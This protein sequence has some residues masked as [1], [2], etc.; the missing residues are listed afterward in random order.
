M[1]AFSHSTTRFICWLLAVLM[2]V[3]PA[4][5][6]VL[7]ENPI[8]LDGR[9]QTTISEAGGNVTNI[10]TETKS[11]VT[12]FNS[13]E[14]FNVLEDHTV[15]LHLPTGTVNLIN[16]VSGTEQTTISG[17]LNSVLADGS[18]GGNLYLLN[19]NGILVG[20]S[21]T[22]N[23]G[24]L[25]MATASRSFI[26]NL[27]TDPISYT[28]DA[29]NQKVLYSPNEYL[30]SQVLEGSIPLTSN[31]S[32]IVKGKINAGFKVELLANH[33]SI[34]EG[35]AVQLD[36][37]FR[38]PYSE[39][40]N[41]QGIEQAADVEV[42]DS[43]TIRILGTRDV[44]I[45]G[46]VSADGSEKHRD[47]GSI[48]IETAGGDYSNTT[49]DYTKK[50]IYLDEN[51]KE[52]YENTGNPLMGEVQY[53]VKKKDASGNDTPFAMLFA[54]ETDAQAE[55]YALLQLEQN[56]DGSLKVYQ[57]GD[58]KYCKKL[59]GTHVS[60]TDDS[61][62]SL[63]FFTVQEQE[64][65]VEAN[66]VAAA[67]G[68]VNV[69]LSPSA[70]IHANGAA[71]SGTLAR[72]NGGLIEVAADHKIQIDASTA[73]GIFSANG[74]A[75]GSVELTSNLVDLSG[76]V[77]SSGDFS[78]KASAIHWDGGSDGL[79]YFLKGGS[80]FNSKV[81]G[82]K[83][84]SDGI[85][86][87]STGVIHLKN[88]HI[89]TRS[90]QEQVSYASGA[91]RWQ[92]HQTADSTGNSGSVTIRADALE[93][94][95]SDILTSVIASSGSGT[96]LT[97]GK[98]TIRL[99]DHY[100]S[101]LTVDG[102]SYEVG[103]SMK[104]STLDAG[105]Y[106]RSPSG[107]LSL[108]D[109]A[110]V[111]IEL[112]DNSFANILDFG[113]RASAGFAQDSTSR[114]TG[115]S[116][117]LKV[118][119]ASGVALDSSSADPQKVKNY[120]MTLLKLL[121]DLTSLVASGRN[122]QSRA[123]AN[124]SGTIQAS[125]DL[126]VQT[127]SAADANF[128]TYGTNLGC[129]VVN[130]LAWSDLKIGSTAS[131]AANNLSVTSNLSTSI[132]AG[133]ANSFLG[134]S[135]SIGCIPVDVGATIVLLE[136][137]NNL[138]VEAGATLKAQK[139]LTLKALTTNEI[140]ANT[141]SCGE[142][143]YLG[144]AFTYLGTNV[145]T[146]LTL[147]DGTEASHVTL[148]G[149]TLNVSAETKL[150]TSNSAY[151]KVGG[152]AVF[153][154]ETYLNGISNGKLA[155]IQGGISDWVK[156][157][158]SFLKKVDTSKFGM[159]FATAVQ[160]SDAKNRLIVG[161][162]SVLTGTSALNLTS[163]MTFDYQNYAYSMMG[164]DYSQQHAG[165]KGLTNVTAAVGLPVLIHS[166]TTALDVCQNAQLRGD[167]ISLAATTTI[168]YSF[169]HLFN[170]LIH[171]DFSKLSAQTL[172]DVL[173]DDTL[174]LLK[175]T[176]NSM[177][178]SSTEAKN[179]GIAGAI[180]VQVITNSSTLKVCDGVKI[181]GADGLSN[182]SSF[183]ASAK[184]D[185]TSINMAG[186]L[187]SFFA[188][189]PNYK[190]DAAGKKKWASCFQSMWG[191]NAE[192]A[193]GA[194]VLWTQFDDT[195]IADVSASQILAK[196]VDV[197]AKS[198]IVNV[199]ISVGAG[200]AKSFGFEGMFSVSNLS[201][202][203]LAKIDDSTAI[204]SAAAPADSVSVTANDAIVNVTVAGSILKSSGSEKTQVT[205]GVGAGIS[206]LNRETYAIWGNL[207]DSSGNLGT[208]K[209]YSQAETLAAAVTPSR[210]RNQTNVSAK[211][212]GVDVVYALSGTLNST[213]D[214]GPDP[215]GNEQGIALMN[216]FDE[217]GDNHILNENLHSAV[218]ITADAS[219]SLI[220]E[221][222]R[223]LLN[224][225]SSL[226]FNPDGT[227]KIGSGASKISV[228][229][230][231]DSFHHA[232]A[233]SASF[234]WGKAYGTSGGLAG[235][236]AFI[237]DTATTQAIL[238]L[239]EMNYYSGLTSGFTTSPNQIL[240]NV[241]AKKS[242]EIIALAISADGVFTRSDTK[243]ALAGSGSYV[244]IRDDTDALVTGTTL[245]IGSAGSTLSDAERLKLQKLADAALSAKNTADIINIAG[246]VSLG[247]SVGVGGAVGIGVIEQNTNALLK[248]VAI[249]GNSLAV[250]TTNSGLIVNVAVGTA[251]SGK[252]E[253]GFTFSGSVAIGSVSGTSQA[254]MVCLTGTGL[255]N[256][257][258][259]V[260]NLTG[261]LSV[262]AANS[263]KLTEEKGAS[264]NQF[265]Y[266]QLLTSEEQGL[267]NEWN[268]K[269]LYLGEDLSTV[270]IKEGE[271][272][273]ING[274]RGE[275]IN[276]NVQ[277]SFG[278]DKARI[279]SVGAAV[280]ASKIATG[281]VVGVNQVH[282]TH[283]AIL[284]DAQ[285]TLGGSAA[286]TS[287]SNAGIYAFNVGFSVSSTANLGLSVGVNLLTQNTFVTVKDSTLT[288][289]FPA[290]GTS[291]VRLTD[292]FLAN[293]S[294]LIV[295]ASV[296][297]GIGTKES[298]TG[299]LLASW[300]QSGNQTMVQ[301]ENSTITNHYGSIRAEGTSSSSLI[302]ILI[303]AGISSKSL[304]GN[305]NVAINSIGSIGV[306]DSTDREN[307]ISDALT[308]SY[309]ITSGNS[310]RHQS[311]LRVTQGSAL[312]AAY[313]NLDLTAKT[314]GLLVAVGLSISGGKVGAATLSG[315]YAN[316]GAITV[317]E[318]ANS[319]LTA[320]EYVTTTVDAAVAAAVQNSK[321]TL[322]EAEKKALRD[323]FTT[324][325]GE[326]APDGSGRV[327]VASE[328]GGNI[329]LS[330]SDSSKLI[331]IVVGGAGG[332]KGAVAVNCGVSTV[333]QSLETLL[334]ASVITASNQIASNLSGDGLFIM[335]G[336]NAAIGLSG[337]GVGINFNYMEYGTTMKQIVSD[338]SITSGFGSID[339]SNRSNED[340]YLVSA[341]GAISQYVSVDANVGIAMLSNTNLVR[342]TS[343]ADLTAGGNVLLAA[344]STNHIFNLT[345]TVAIGGAGGGIGANAVTSKVTTNT[346]V[347]VN[348]DGGSANAPTSI[349]SA[350][351]FQQT[352]KLMFD[353]NEV[354]GTGIYA[355]TK[356][357]LQ[358]L[359]ISAA[360]GEYFGVSGNVSVLINKPTTKT[361]VT[362]TDLNLR[363]R[364]S[365]YLPLLIYYDA[366]GELQFQEASAN[367]KA[368]YTQNA[369]LDASGWNF[370]GGLAGGAGGVQVGI[371][372]TLLEPTTESILSSIR[373]VREMMPG[374][375]SFQGITPVQ[376][377]G[378]TVSANLNDVSVTAASTMD[379]MA[380]QGGAAGG[381]VG[382]SGGYSLLKLS[383]ATRAQILSSDLNAHSLT[384]DANS[385]LNLQSYSV[386][387]GGGIGGVV[388]AGAEVISNHD[389]EAAVGRV[390]NDSALHSL[391]LSG[392][393]KIN[394]AASLKLRN[395]L[396][397]V[398]G[399]A[400]A[401]IVN[402]TRIHGSDSALA[403]IADNYVVT[404][405]RNITMDARHTLTVEEI[406]GQLAGGGAVGI[407][408]DVISMQSGAYVQV[409]SGT[410]LSARG[411]ASL[412][413]NVFNN[414]QL[415]DIGINVGL[416]GIQASISVIN[417]S[418]SA[419][420]ETIRIS[421]RDY[422]AKY[423]DSVEKSNYDFATL[424]RG[425][426][427]GGN[428]VDFLQGKMDVGDEFRDFYSTASES[429]VN[430][431]LSTLMASAAQGSGSPN[432]GAVT[433]LS[434][435]QSAVQLGKE[436]RISAGGAVTIQAQNH[437]DFDFTTVAT[438][439]EGISLGGAINLSYLG[440]NV[441]TQIG[442]DVLSD[443]SIL[444]G[445]SDAL[446][447]KDG[448]ASASCS[449]GIGQ[450]AAV[451][452]AAGVAY[453]D[454][455]GT[456]RIVL[457]GASRESTAS[458]KIAQK[459][460]TNNLTKSA[461][462]SLNA[463]SSH[464]YSIQNGSVDV[465]GAGAAGIVSHILDTS[466]ASI[467][468]TSAVNLST[469]RGSINLNAS[470]NTNYELNTWG[471][472]VNLVGAVGDESFLR[473]GTAAKVTLADGS[474]VRAGLVAQNSGPH[475]FDLENE[476]DPNSGLNSSQNNSEN[477][478]DSNDSEEQKN[479]VN[480][481]TMARSTGK[482]T[483]K[484]IDA[485]V[486][487]T[488]GVSRDIA[489]SSMDSIITL[490]NDVTLAGDSVSL[491]AQTL[492]QLTGKGTAAGGSL[493][494]TANSAEAYFTGTHNA[495][496]VTGSRL[497]AFTWA[498][499]EGQR[500]GT[501]SM[502][503][504]TDINSSLEAT[505][506]GGSVGIAIGVV[507]SKN[508][509]T[510]N[511]VIHVGSD[512]ILRAGTVNLTAE[513]ASKIASDLTGGAGAILA[514]SGNVLHSYYTPTAEITFD[515]NSAG[516]LT[517]KKRNI[518]ADSVLLK[519]LAAGSVDHRNDSR[520]G[521]LVSAGGAG[522]RFGIT[523]V[524]VLN[525]ANIQIEAP[526]IRIQ[527]LTDLLMP[528][529]DENT[530]L[531]SGGLIDAAATRGNSV[532]LS[533]ESTVNIGDSAL[534]TTGTA[535]TDGLL[536]ISAENNLTSYDKYQLIAGAAIAVTHAD[537]ELNID[538]LN[539][540]VN[541]GKNA[542]LFSNQTF[543][544]GALSNA[545]VFFSVVSKSYGLAGV[546]VSQG[547]MLLNSTNTVN[548]GEGAS[549]LSW[550]TLGLAA[551]GL[552]D[553]VSKWNL[554]SY[555]YAYTG[556]AIPISASSTNHHYFNLANNIRT[557]ANSK[558]QSVGDVHLLS[559]AG[560]VRNVA[561][562]SSANLYST[563]GSSSISEIFTDGSGKLNSSSKDSNIQ[564]T[565]GVTIAGEVAAGIHAD[566]FFLVKP[567]D[568]S[569]GSGDAPVVTCSDWFS[570][571]L[572]EDVALDLSYGEQIANLEAEIAKFDQS[573]EKAYADALRNELAYLKLLQQQYAGQKADIISL[574]SNSV[575]GGDVIAHG[576]Y[577]ATEGSQAILRAK[578]N[579]KLEVTND[580]GAFLQTANLTVSGTGNGKLVFNANQIASQDQ[581]NRL[582]RENKKAAFSVFE[583][584]TQSSAV[585][586][587]QITSSVSKA[588]LW[589]NGTILNDYGSVVVNSKGSIRQAG[590][591]SAQ[592]VKITTAGSFIQDYTAGMRNLGGNPST[593][594]AVLA[595]MNAFIYRMQNSDTENPNYSGSTAQN[596]KMTSNSSLV[597]GGSVFIA[598]EYLNLNGMI[599]SGMADYA[600]D[601]GSNGILDKVDAFLSEFKAGRTSTNI[602]DLTSDIQIS[603]SG[604]TS[605]IPVKVQF[606]AET[607]TL[608]VDDLI[609]R[610]GSIT[611]YGNILSTGNGVIYAASGRSSVSISNPSAYTLSLGDI[612]VSTAAAGRVSITDTAYQLLDKNGK[613]TGLNT[614]FESQSGQTIRTSVLYD[615]ATRKILY[616][617]HGNECLSVTAASTYSPLANRWYAW[618]TQ[619][620][621][622]KMQ[623]E[624]KWEKYVFWI[625]AGSS[626]S[627]GKTAVTVNP[628][629]KVLSDTLVTDA[630]LDSS[631]DFIAKY[632]RKESDSN[633][634]D[635]KYVKD[636]TRVFV[637]YWEE[638]YERTHT[639]KETESFYYYLNASKPVSVGFN[640]AQ[641]GGN[642]TISSQGALN[643]ASIL[644]PGGSVSITTE[645]P[646][647]RSG[648]SSVIQSADISLTV[649][650]GAKSDLLAPESI[651][652]ENFALMVRQT[653]DLGKPLS[654]NPILN[655][656]AAFGNV[657]LQNT[658][659]STTL[660][661]VNVRG[662][663]L[664]LKSSGSILQTAGS[665]I[666]AR[667]LNLRSESGNV[668]TAGTPLRVETTTPDRTNG[669]EG[670]VSVY[671]MGDVHLREMGRADGANFTDSD[672]YVEKIQS[673]DGNAAITVA[674]GSI[675]N[676]IQTPMLFGDSQESYHA[677]LEEN[678]MVA[679]KA[680][681]EQMNQTFE[682]TEIVWEMLYHEN[683]NG[684]K[685]A[686][687]PNYAFHFTDEQRAQM[688]ASGLSEETIAGQEAQKT[689]FYHET[690]FDYGNASY[691]SKFNYSLAAEERQA[692]SVGSLMT[693]QEMDDLLPLETYG[694]D[695]PVETDLTPHILGR[696]I[697][698]TTDRGIGSLDE[699]LIIPAGTSLKDLSP[700]D[701]DS[702][703]LALPQDVSYLRG[704]DGKVSAMVVQRR[705][706]IVVEATGVVDAKA[707][708]D[709][710]LAS[711]R[712]LTLNSLT[713]AN[714]N[715]LLTLKGNLKANSQLKANNMDFT[716][717]GNVGTETTPVDVLLQGTDTV[718][719]AWAKGS[720][721]FRS[722]SD[723]RITSIRTE[724]ASGIQ[725]ETT[726][727][728]SVLGVDSESATAHLTANQIR[729]TSDG[730]IGT[731]AHA[732]IT[733]A[734]V[735][736]NLP[737]FANW[738]E[739]VALNAASD[740]HLT[741][742]DSLNVVRAQ[743]AS[744]DLTLTAKLQMDLTGNLA[745]KNV[746]L[747]TL[748]N[749]L[750]QAAEGSTV[751]STG[752]ES[753]VR[754]TA[755]QNAV[756]ASVSAEGQTVNVT[757]EEGSILRS[758]A[759]TT[760]NAANAA[761]ALT[762]AT[763]VGSAQTADANTF[764]DALS[765]NV[766]SVTGSVSGA[767]GFF[768]EQLTATPLTASGI[769]TASGS[770]GLLATGA[771]LVKDVT[772][773]G[774]GTAQGDLFVA[775]Q[776]AD[777]TLSGSL[778][779]RNLDAYAGRDLLSGDGLTLNA[780]PTEGSIQL[781]AQNAIR[782]TQP[783][784]FR[785]TH[786]G[787]LR[788]YGKNS[789]TL[790]VR[791]QGLTT[792][793]LLLTEGTAIVT[794]T[795]NADSLLVRE[796]TGSLFQT[797]V[798]AHF[799]DV[800]AENEFAFQP[801]PN[802]ELPLHESLL[803][804]DFTASLK[805]ESTEFDGPAFEFD[806][807]LLD[808]L[809]LKT[810][811]LT[812]H[813]LKQKTQT[814]ERPLTIDVM[815]WSSD[816]TRS[817][818]LERIEAFGPIE[819]SRLWATY[820]ELNVAPLPGDFPADS[821]PFE[822]WPT[823]PS[824]AVADG[825]TDYRIRLNFGSM[826][827]Q[828]DAADRTAFNDRT[829]LWTLDGHFTQRMEP[830]LI[831]TNIYVLNY[832]PEFIINRTFSTEN[833]L[834]RQT[835]K[836]NLLNRYEQLYRQQRA[837]TPHPLFILPPFTSTDSNDEKEE[838][839]L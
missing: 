472:V 350:N 159:T 656:D 330:N 757:A 364:G 306:T 420:P 47:G 753:K 625:G 440:G 794:A 59:D 169:N 243:I 415:D 348:S 618:A 579:A 760:I 49:T 333:R 56:E 101:S 661:S 745:G 138:T 46:E 433:D 417:S 208:I 678:G 484:G 302:A 672:F 305:L 582:N 642:V 453:M 337:A 669:L 15:N 639:W 173:N 117:N 284:S 349:T 690:C 140:S 499:S 780:N 426:D 231:N 230:E 589:L 31:A 37:Q 201:T 378:T 614:I 469:M 658:S 172:F 552:G 813:A 558:V 380:M 751:A 262:A 8:T 32:I 820:G 516:F 712:D 372:S 369:K 620:V 5:M 750:I 18:I 776:N 152:T 213:G 759:G 203:T 451:G 391:N 236:V 332:G 179:L 386:Y 584:N 60:W 411:T 363:S 342:V 87:E 171:G 655:V 600:I 224:G 608:S 693:V 107:T 384:V 257:G 805:V 282:T 436:S 804:T 512:S 562:R 95:N 423:L 253:K 166:N 638:E 88:V 428:Q 489:E 221:T 738:Q 660:A 76:N 496:I 657:Y 65:D 816:L 801:A 716:V 1:N 476:L 825:L 430:A 270:P 741:S 4:P 70:R 64:Y 829:H 412:N 651:G 521:G 114:I 413:S 134:I 23:V 79:Y 223:A 116:V 327:P 104:G 365:E 615:P 334:S 782:G 126:K 676:G 352:K 591:I 191:S 822:F 373:T 764:D 339:I 163:G 722:D 111:S 543:E 450:G 525:L 298:L 573:G 578:G 11:G 358:T 307:E 129:A 304:A 345:P 329:T 178:Q 238:G 418:A 219:V 689:R 559:L 574:D 502:H 725:L 645:S 709:I 677:W 439:L 402:V 313:G 481:A 34:G 69:T 338:G 485:S 351:A 793:D 145:E 20:S 325:L 74:A 643:L 139:D 622:E 226:N 36:P 394:S 758:G 832:S 346:W 492:Q 810:D 531:S 627:G 244:K 211:T 437:N 828:I 477:S 715:L 652:S 181:T 523:A 717:F 357:S 443:T 289:L 458:Q 197:N 684:G 554:E 799:I 199:G 416:A 431:G 514:A 699:A 165:T 550:G 483:A 94:E 664:N 366:N 640:E 542:D 632:Y 258:K 210:V 688:L 67:D 398:A 283:E 328:N 281:A 99:T 445:A 718:L 155:K 580:S 823:A 564:F 115:G 831:D 467:L 783:T 648:N 105:V 583:I 317:L 726:N 193:L 836:E 141:N 587:I 704:M 490:G 598:A 607:E 519:A 118:L 703:Q 92:R 255:P 404:C 510:A 344:T 315:S 176:M 636:S 714:G 545:K 77:I 343:G 266:T 487:I 311:G 565:G 593:N 205:I 120:G 743:S 161:A 408:V 575:S 798:R 839:Q 393:L 761:L 505:G 748:T 406:L 702:L 555:V 624:F 821:V 400:G 263:L 491:D 609:C 246:G 617:E 685:A 503:A 728:A 183:A 495:K 135:T 419:V 403:G 577:F 537:S 474:S 130:N 619:Q 154:S 546:A 78:V 186:A 110:A 791:D 666:F 781:A 96:S 570:W 630:S 109:G 295:G 200:S 536:S 432:S 527:A 355:K 382:A 792:I 293:D 473:T 388:G 280:S 538:K 744:G 535:R 644:A 297:A 769:T 175:G 511:S 184:T 225:N 106:S 788:L 28:D 553:R 480:L 746:T 673:V 303:Q 12:A 22:I 732:L 770:V 190:K 228:L 399:G 220:E 144:L 233:G 322:S 563:V 268:D 737:S 795:P 25:G 834:E 789:V 362:S 189:F 196:S 2:A 604:I 156:G 192:K 86:L 245:R 671:A 7:A 123:Y 775:S 51:G 720:V 14:K 475:D 534:L 158:L 544:I 524:S 149:G 312:E 390:K 621:F 195:T 471:V 27:L 747:T 119:A 506:V 427:G 379:F 410:L 132:S 434:N 21:G 497:N 367:G 38:I 680:Y 274:T 177:A 261:D 202:Y 353:G 319:S 498:N 818:I 637:F 301:I 385:F 26:E 9:T 3:G 517:D 167:K 336:G 653:D 438:S 740:V 33:V 581:L 66:E 479:V 222:T 321:K 395:Y 323:Y 124:L 41:V 787:A 696:N 595:A 235:S 768:V 127:Y 113:G 533:I 187:R 414:L 692:L 85:S 137:K 162:N 285:I 681:D 82:L 508:N 634:T 808:S 80:S 710:V 217:I 237:R 347:D 254:G 275:V 264:A 212:T 507:Q 796:F 24:S 719:S 700:E 260:V 267:L 318:V 819:V 62:T 397:S 556:A 39:I 767:G 460:Q 296:Q 626:Y 90:V 16:T 494:G 247:G 456:A 646:I 560:S 131:L 448:K 354:Q 464:R 628:Q 811:E 316:V 392:D 54:S 218:G 371:S 585:P 376:P 375:V 667:G 802:A 185:V 299:N 695:D 125:G 361:T 568:G 548:V 683:W 13:F 19:P 44:A 686:Y 659:G 613:T 830:N 58:S 93:M 765:T 43:D 590:T 409:G 675:L 256:D 133:W 374:E 383:G 146:N 809:R 442:G 314:S 424:F 691:D 773:G 518:Q 216:L 697:S 515:A 447:S 198:E 602:L 838:S 605:S 520:F 835:N 509:F 694:T 35:A 526:A 522:N 271:T 182:A 762:A 468:G 674:G 204:G 309:G 756:L 72:G 168:P 121:T 239:T 242:G 599:L 122:N 292:A 754:I 482:V 763:G 592:T 227:G 250:Q 206:N 377:F 771:L 421:D 160:V 547:K 606:N 444:I 68:T 112:R 797:N 100:S 341:S 359:G 287:G 774:S 662:G 291:A 733:E 650:A 294:S 824:M 396:F 335:G 91:E 73:D 251:I 457:D 465:Q 45:A 331:N 370:S 777:V 807:L 668:G 180:T 603:Q 641:N 142:K 405:G 150:T 454:Y 755:R 687:D 588:E 449:I 389:T 749:D 310:Y 784:G 739:N 29:G 52:T 649:N 455:S 425:T 340:L 97:A 736:R 368:N 277:L 513:T 215:D 462:I 188:Q 833:S 422:T 81:D 665:T 729:V 633:Y 654:E 596:L 381:I 446:D 705:S 272:T 501:V 735:S 576:N 308:K 103:M 279:I 326:T 742:N 567:G 40:V 540:T 232:L 569:G 806:S 815:G 435:V 324:L 249:S 670:N 48:R 470:T 698:L 273:G 288:N 214:P 441:L 209:G 463:S 586:T 356:Q 752:S 151:A 812:L 461:A 174:G 57:D 711:S 252:M 530:Y 71:A 682:G 772:I 779:A 616:D 61:T 541:V 721:N 265:D 207:T 500:T 817:A 504:K 63:R 278:N 234:S 566:S 679:G 157:K 466:E 170:D 229:A 529:R 128:T 98:I 790:D 17:T 241:N 50:P 148:A 629:K 701:V 594:D 647:S 42:I 478:D 814:G 730:T 286:V 102:K 539:A 723:L 276:K 827:S 387:L 610:G 724:D 136:T 708:N 551:G 30:T 6:Q 488:I 635:W 401:L 597:V 407:G 108:T 786:S 360:G 803:P 707:Q 75:P 240:L 143:D 153:P 766:A 194:G 601:F 290:E 10:T 611:L 572:Q 612:D 320:N 706:Q 623:D 571:N 429:S 269:Q 532:H 452:I 727:G 89:S 837:L 493:I 785:S 557:A 663:S 248:N 459:I 731:A 53:S 486:G 83:A 826:R 734:A 778:S 549:L 631:K 259:N 713:A 147:A 164:A 55:N 561:Y 528:E 84:S 300:N 800:D